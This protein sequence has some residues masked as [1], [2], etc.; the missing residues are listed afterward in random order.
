MAITETHAVVRNPEI[1][2]DTILEVQKFRPS[3]ALFR[4]ATAACAL[5]L[6]G[7][8]LSGLVPGHYLTVPMGSN[9]SGL[10]EWQ[11]GK[12]ILCESLGFEV[13]RGWGENKGIVYAS[14]TWKPRISLES[15]TCGVGCYRPVDEGTGRVQPLTYWGSKG[16]LYNPATDKPGVSFFVQDATEKTIGEVLRGCGVD[17]QRA[18]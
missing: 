13:V 2:L 9:I 16:G 10:E 14:L 8:D 5:R 6:D 4:L 17:T 11:K 1:A 12:R 15:E 3:Q 18:A 7:A